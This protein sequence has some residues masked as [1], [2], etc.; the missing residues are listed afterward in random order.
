L[1]QAISIKFYFVLSF[2]CISGG[3][4]AQRNQFSFAV[5]FFL[6]STTND[7]SICSGSILSTNF[8]L[9][10]AHCFVNVVDG[11]LL[12]GVHNIFE[13]FPQYELEITRSDI[14]VHQSYDQIRQ[15]NDIALVS[16]RRSPF[17]Y[18][19]YIQPIQIIP[20][21]YSNANL[22]GTSARIAGW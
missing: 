2:L 9:S 22:T 14:T 5:V 15:T 7:D 12:A 17:I 16:T 3:T 4:E 1:L 21:S 18:S 20:R 6:H 10:A 8:V 13:E 11:E 19:A